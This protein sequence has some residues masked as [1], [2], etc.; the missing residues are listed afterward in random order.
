M[1]ASGR[2][3][4]GELAAY[5]LFLTAFFAPVQA[6]VQLYNAYQQGG[7]AIAKLRELFAT[8][9]TVAERPGAADLAL[10]RGEIVFDR[11]SFA[12]RADREVI[13]D[14]SLRIAAGRDAGGGGR[15]RFGARP[16]WPG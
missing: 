13:H 10:I 4:V 9:P 15:D 11:V 8:E 6:L 3:T 2:I 1:T 7:A 12:Y 14:V 5:L 16:R